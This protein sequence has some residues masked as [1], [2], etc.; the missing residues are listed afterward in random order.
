[1]LKIGYSG[2]PSSGKTTTARALAGAL[3]AN[4]S[5][6]TIELV[7][8]YA[9]KYLAKYGI[10]DIT[11]QIRILA[12]QKALEDIIP[13]TVDVMITDSPI[14]LGFNYSLDLRREGNKKDTMLLND[15]F[16]ELSKCNETPRYDIIFHISPKAEI[17]NDGVRASHH[18]D[19]KWREI[20]ELKT[21]A[22]YY[23]FKP[24]LFV[25]LKGDTVEQRVKESIAYIKEFVS[26]QP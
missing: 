25:C 23:I 11:D 12:K 26:N 8:E 24:R 13:P 19:P 14:F 20:A 6:K 2:I 22:L 18:L 16:K 5:F 15:L 1:M 4:S 17:I 21:V 9:R 10:E 7:D 3:R